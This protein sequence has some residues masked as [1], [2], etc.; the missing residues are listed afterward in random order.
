MDENEV[1]VSAQRVLEIVEE[2]DPRLFQMAVAQARNEVLTEQIA[3]LQS[4]LSTMAE[5]LGGD[6]PEAEEP[7]ED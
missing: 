2:A 4:A 3:H 6:T 5:N 7:A 1:T